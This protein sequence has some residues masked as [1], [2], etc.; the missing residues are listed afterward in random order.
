MLHVVGLQAVADAQVTN[1]GQ[2]PGVP[3]IQVP[4]VLHDPNGVKVAL[5]CESTVHDAVPQ[6]APVSATQD[7]VAVEQ[8]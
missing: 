5:P 7:P 1:P 2:G 6:L 8:A 4:E 3:G